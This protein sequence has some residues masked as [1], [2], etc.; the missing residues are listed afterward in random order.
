MSNIWIATH[1]FLLSCVCLSCGTPCV[2]FASSPAKPKAHTNCNAAITS[3]ELINTFVALSNILIDISVIGFLSS[4]MCSGSNLL[5]FRVRAHTSTHP[6]YHLYLG[7][8]Y[9]STPESFV[10]FEITD[11][12]FYSGTNDSL[13]LLIGDPNYIVRANY[14][15]LM[16]CWTDLLVKQQNI[17]NVAFIF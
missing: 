5:R 12:Y 7:E 1:D 8:M 9:V 13:L 3:F 4:I 2:T 14:R 16:M 15:H 17:I 6:V 11:R 10:S